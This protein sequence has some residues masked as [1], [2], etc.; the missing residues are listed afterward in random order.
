MLA[1]TIKP[2]TTGSYKPE[3]HF[4]AMV[5]IGGRRLFATMRG[6][7]P[8]VVLEPGA[9]G[10]GTWG[11]V[12][13]QVAGF[14]S[15]LTYDRAGVGKSDAADVDATV[16]L[17]AADCH[18]LLEK[19]DVKK[20]VVLVGW[21]LSGLSALCHA[22]DYPADIAA[23]VLV[24][25]TPH[26]LYDDTS[27]EGRGPDLDRQV[28]VQRWL[29]HLG[30]GRFW[31]RSGIKQFL[32]RHTGTIVD[33][34]V[35][36]AYLESMISIPRS[37]A[38]GELRAM[39]RSCQIAKTKLSNGL[40]DIPLIVL[41]ASIN[42]ANKPKVTENMIMAHKEMAAMSSQGEFRPV[43]NGSHMMTLDRPDA[44]VAA[45]REQVQKVEDR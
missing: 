32:L 16:D 18:A 42:S 31:G 38:A 3:P 44:I 5:D 23:L 4:A 9:S 11:H 26:T 14:A 1:S 19:M 2:F 13:E 22:I 39:K 17:M 34:T 27:K 7:G 33:E 21:S 35:L 40:P 12:V 41:S 36:E 29:S 30:Y 8:L 6:E 28:L 45:I 43:A 10:G 24:D 25:P 37:P 15:V 20:P